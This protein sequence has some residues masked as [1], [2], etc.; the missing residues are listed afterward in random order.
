MSYAQRMFHQPTSRAQHLGQL[1]IVATLAFGIGIATRSFSGPALLTTT[2]D[3]TRQAAVVAPVAGNHAAVAVPGAAVAMTELYDGGW[4]GGPG[5]GAV[6]SSA[7]AVRAIVPALTEPYDGGWA[8]G[9]GPGAEISSA[10]AV[11]AAAPATT[12]L[13]DGGWAGGPGPQR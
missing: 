13:Y 5:P 12:D 7:P 4:A 9:P 10:P 11:R 6:I 1:A 2:S 8:G 3:Q